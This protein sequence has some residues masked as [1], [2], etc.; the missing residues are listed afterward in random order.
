MQTGRGIRNDE[1]QL[2]TLQ[3]KTGSFDS[4]REMV[5]QRII[6]TNGKQNYLLEEEIGFDERDKSSKVDI[7][8]H[9]TT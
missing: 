5:S 7:K 4:M 1:N 8:D 9:S 6:T 3:T 2:G